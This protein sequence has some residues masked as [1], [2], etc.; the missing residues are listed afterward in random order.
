[1]DEAGIFVGWYTGPSGTGIQITDGKGNSINPYPY[2]YTIT[3]YP[4][5]DVDMDTLS[6][7]LQRD[8]TY[9]V[10]AGS[11]IRT[12]T[13]VRIPAIYKGIAVSR[14]LDGAFTSCSNLKSIYIPDTITAIGVGAFENCS[15]LTEYVVYKGRHD[16]TY[17]PLYSSDNGALIYKDTASNRVYL[18]AF[19]R[20]KTGAYTVPAGVEDI[21]PFA[22]NSAKISSVTISK[23]VIYIAEN[24]FYKCM[25]LTSI[26]FEY[27]RSATVTVDPNAF[28]SVGK[29]TTIKF[30][31]LITAFQD[32]KTF[33]DTFTSL[34]TVEVEAGG[35]TYTSVE[36]FLC[37]ANPQGVA[38]LYIPKSFS[39]EFEAPTGVASI[40]AKLFQNNLAITSVVI[41][42][43]V[44]SVGNDAFNGATNL[45]SVKIDGTRNQPLTIGNN[46]FK[47]C[48]QL[49]SVEIIGSQSAGNGAI[50]F[51]S[52]VFA[53]C[54]SLASFTAG[55]NV[56]I[57]NL[58]TYTFNG[59][60]ALATISI[61]PSATLTKIG[62]NAFYGCTRIKS[63]ETHSTTTTVGNQAFGGCTNLES[64]TFANSSTPITFGERVFYN[65]TSLSTIHIPASVTEFKYSVFEDCA[66][67]TQV[68]VD[69][70]STIFESY[71]GALYTKGRS[72]LL[73]YPKN[74]DGNLA[75]L[76]WSDLTKI[77]ASVFKNN[78]KITAVTFG[79]NIT[80]IGKGAFE[81]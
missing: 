51:G 2:D 11:R 6:Y 52:S 71:K 69:P 80:E 61:S 63:V 8:G 3:V 32:V 47:T 29:V 17:E 26:E 74:L 68:I 48:R 12:V 15:G 79:A 72:E 25:N 45:T 43:H 4:F 60:T 75:N 21:R 18:E 39:G 34:T 77:G 41:P 1:D 9:G 19:P 40:G 59:N 13:N 16:I 76:P 10:K 55:D 28:S 23:D 46:A 64:F 24:A 37:D 81:G 22:F 62:D 30:P 5:F 31:A 65:C 50:T 44:S 42:S 49:K 20:A 78:P 27:Q 14:I 66:A 58:G 56:N 57:A 54:T 36:G 33:L 70:N 73:F 35:S 7:E 38:I 53:S 67:L